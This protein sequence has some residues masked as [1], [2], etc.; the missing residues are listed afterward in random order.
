MDF[1]DSN[2]PLGLAMTGFLDDYS[3]TGNRRLTEAEKEEMIFRYKDAESKAR[4][5]QIRNA[6][7]DEEIANDL[8]GG[9]GIG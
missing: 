7:P 9:P 6:V 8:F 3:Q 5:E 4:K 1:K 2:L